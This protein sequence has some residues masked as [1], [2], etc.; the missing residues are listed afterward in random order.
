M[1]RFLTLL[2]AVVL[3]VGLA[4]GCGGDKEK[5]KNKNKDRPQAADKNE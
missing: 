1:K 4:A 5:D 2:C 3:F